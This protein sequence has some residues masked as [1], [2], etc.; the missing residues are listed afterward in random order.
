M[1]AFAFAA[2]LPRFVDPSRGSV[3]IDGH[4]V[5]LATLESLRSEVVWAGGANCWFTGSVVENIAGGDQRFSLSQVT[6]AAKRTHAHSFIQR[7]SQGYET[8]VGEHGEQLSDSQGFR[9]SLA[10]AILRDPAVL[11]IE[12]PPEVDSEDEKALLEDACRNVSKGRTVISLPARMRT[13]K[14][15]DRIVLLNRGQIEVVGTHEALLKTSSLYRHWE[16]L[17]FNEF[18]RAVSPSEIG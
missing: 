4:D 16:Y 6:E 11:I 13:L 12:E 1:E 8:V 3:T 2:L 9:L 14:A 5:S 17:H 10:R 7:F 15:A 18:R